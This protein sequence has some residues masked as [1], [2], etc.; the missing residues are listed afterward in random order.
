MRRGILFG[1]DGQ[2][3]RLQVESF[4]SGNSSQ[5]RTVLDKY[6]EEPGH[7]RRSPKKRIR[8]QLSSE[9]V[10]LAHR[11]VTS[12]QYEQLLH[13]A[14]QKQRAQP[15]KKDSLEQPLNPTSDYNSLNKQIKQ[16]LSNKSLSGDKKL[17]Y[18]N[19]QH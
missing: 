5:R 14:G 7:R 19:F 17:K 2:D 10:T 11:N 4:H 15:S 1:K 12:H 6:G 9:V 13:K 16:R 8:N 18:R 3:Q